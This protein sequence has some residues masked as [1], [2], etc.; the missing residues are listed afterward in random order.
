MLF[1]VGCTPDQNDDPADTDMAE[2]VV[3]PT[4]FATDLE[5]GEQVI[6]VTS[7]ATW[8][9]SCDQADVTV[10]PLTG[11]GNGTVTITVPA[12][13][14]REFKVVFSAQKQTT[15][16]ALGTSTTT[17][18]KAEVAVSQNAGGVNLDDYL[19]Y[20]DCGEDVEKN[21]NGY[22]PYVDAF[23]GWNPQG[24]AAA[25]VSYGGN[26]A[27][28]RASGNAYQ[29]TAEAVG[30][31]GQPYVFLNKVPSSAHF[32]IENIAVTGGTNYI[33]TYNAQCQ[34]GYSGTPTF[35]TVDGTLIH[36]ELSYDG[37]TWANAN[38]TYTPNGG[39]GWYAVQVEFKTAATATKLY[40]RFT[41]EAPA[42][43]GG[44][45]FDDFKL[46]AGGNGGELDFT[47]TPPT[48]P[49]L[50]EQPT[51]P[52]TLPYS[53]TF[54]SNQGYFTIENTVLP[55]ELSYVWAYAAGYG[56]KGSA[57]T[58]NTK[59]AAESWLVSP[60]ISLVGATAPV[61]TFSHAVNKLDAGTP[62]DW[63]TLHIK[64]VGTETWNELAIPT[65]G[66]GTSWAFV[67][68]GEVD[69]SAYIGKNVQIAFKYTS[70]TESAGTWEVKNVLVAEG[71][72]AEPEQ[73]ADGSTVATI[74]FNQMGYTNAQNVD[75]QT[76][77]VDENISL[78]FAKGGA[79]TAPAYYDASQGIRMYQNGATLDVTAANGKT[80]SSIVFEFDYNMWYLGCD[81][82][83][84]SE[85]SSTRTWT[86]SASAIKFTCIGTDKNSRAY[87]KSMKITYK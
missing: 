70:S 61:L 37:T 27:S 24:E 51:D 40:A 35:A 23:E 41:Y 57:F 74:V 65:H 10:E 7:N 71:G 14:Q 11:S 43:N 1:G 47:V 63:F 52:L 31:S 60:Q 33:F 55:A 72:S 45:R 6:A 2:I 20:E 54:A 75:G 48:E 49:E 34:N 81:S 82:G 87:I 85:A 67:D 38:C 58:N 53:E 79:S 9:V 32:L 28:V 80:I 56:M 13:A 84:L 26:N 46:V 62:A 30:I 68:S 42:S 5:G 59:Y 76:I 3:S 25:N 83:E 39:N 15:I 4:S 29:P 21:E 19:F 73:P 8:T 22:W 77:T 18:A 16:P 44:G 86:G 50:P 64:E 66:T 78:V 69:L 36:L 12:A 17:T